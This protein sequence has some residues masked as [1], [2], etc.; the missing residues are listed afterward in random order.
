MIAIWGL[1]MIAV[2]GPTVPLVA[3]EV[4]EDHGPRAYGLVNSALGAGTVVGGLLA[5][6]LRPAG[7]CAP[8]RSPWSASAP[9]RRPSARASACP[10]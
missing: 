1:Y 9:S 10:P 8:D 6:R 4:V 3:T 7:C 5:L 2:S